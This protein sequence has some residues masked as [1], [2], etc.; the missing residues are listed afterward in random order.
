M[1]DPPDGS[2]RGKPS[3]SALAGDLPA[4]FARGESALAEIVAA[5]HFGITTDEFEAIVRAWLATAR[6]PKT[7]RLFTEMVFQPMLELIARLRTNG[8]KTF[9]VSAGGVEFMRTFAETT[10]NVPP[11]QV[12]RSSAGSRSR[13]ATA[14]RSLPR[15][16]PNLT[17]PRVS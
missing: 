1:A 8:F 9:I 10:Y 17:R 7:N 3:L 2:A 6:H 14:A 5:T 13:C 16:R 11:E 4:I 12:I 15:K